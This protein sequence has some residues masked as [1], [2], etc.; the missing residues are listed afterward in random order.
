MSR[1]AVQARWN[2]IQPDFAALRPDA[3]WD[4]YQGKHVAK[5]LADL[6]VRTGKRIESVERY[7]GPD[8]YMSLCYCW[9]FYDSSDRI[10]DLEWQYKSD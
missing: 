3:G 9:F 1:E 7:W 4:A 10:V 5:V 8:G 6:E 2:P